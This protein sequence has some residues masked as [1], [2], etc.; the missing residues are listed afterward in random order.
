[1]K[2]LLVL[3]LLV[4]SF[5]LFS[6]IDITPR[7]LILKARDNISFDEVTFENTEINNIFE[8]YR[9]RSI[10]KLFP[11]DDRYFCVRFYDDLDWN[12]LTKKAKNIE[13]IEYIQPNYVNKMHFY[14]NDPRYENQFLDM[15]NAEQSWDI[16]TGSNS[17]IIAIIDSGCH[18]E[19][20]DLQG[21]I[22]I[23]S[24]EIA[25][26]GIDDDD[27]GYVDDWRGWDF[28]DAPE[29]SEVALGDYLD[30]DND[31]EDENNHGTHVAGIIGADS[32][33]SIGITGICH[34]TSMLIV[35]AGF[36]TTQGT[37]YLQDDDCASAIVYAANM[38]ANLINIS[39]GDQTHSQIIDDACQYAYDH[40]TIIVAS[41]GNDPQPGISFPARLATTIS[42]GA[43]DE[44]MNLGGFSSYG[45]EMDIVAPG[46][47]IISTYSVDDPAT[48]YHE[49]SGTSMAAPFV[50]GA[51]GL[52]LSENPGISFDEAKSRLYSSAYNLGPVGFD[53]YFGMGMLDIE[54][55]LTVSTI[56]L[57]EITSPD[58]RTGFANSFD[59]V[60]TVD[61]ED[62]FRYSVMYTS[63]EMPE[64]IDWK[65][66]EN[67]ETTPLFYTENVVNGV[68]A[69]FNLR[70][71][72]SDGT[73]LIKVELTTSDYRKFTS[74]R[75]VYLDQTSPILDASYLKIYKRYFEETPRYYLQS[76]YDEPVY[77]KT[78]ITDMNSK[79]YTIYNDYPDSSLIIQFPEEL[80]EGPV[81]L[82]ISAENLCGKLNAAQTFN[83]VGDIDKTTINTTEYNQIAI[84]PAITGINTSNPNIIIGM[85]AGSGYGDVHIF[86][87]S[88]GTMQTAYSFDGKFWPLD[89]GNTNSTHEELIGIN[90][91]KIVIYESNDRNNFTLPADTILTKSDVMGARFVNFDTDVYDELL[92]I[93]NESF[94][95]VI[96]GYDRNSNVFINRFTLHNTSPT[97]TRN[98][99]STRITCGDFDNDGYTDIV[100][101]DSDGDVMVYEVHSNYETSQ[102]WAFRLPT[103]NAFFITSG[104]YTGDG[105]KEFC[106]GGYTESSGNPEKTFSFFQV[107]KST[108]P[109]TYEPLDYIS[110]DHIGSQNS[111]TSVDFDDDDDDE[112]VISMSPGVYIVDYIDGHL[113]P[114]WKGESDRTYQAFSIDKNGSEP[115][116]VFLNNT[117]DDQYEC[118]MVTKAAV[119]DRPFPPNQFKAAPI[120]ENAILLS[121]KQLITGE[122]IIY[123]IEDDNM[124]ELA[125]VTGN[126]FIDTL[127]VASKEYQYALAT[128]D[129][130][131]QYNTSKLSLWKTVMPDYKPELVEMSFIDQDRLSLEFSRPLDNTAVDIGNY[132]I[133]PDI[134]LPSSCYFDKHKTRVIL[135]FSQNFEQD[136]PYTLSIS[137]LKGDSGVPLDDVNLSVTLDG[138]ELIKPYI[139]NIK[140]I[141]RNHLEINYSEVVSEI[142]AT[143]IN[144]YVIS[145]PEIDKNNSIRSITYNNDQVTIVFSNELEYANKV[146]DLNVKNVE[147]LD[148]N[149]IKLGNKFLFSLTVINNLDHVKIVPNPLYTSKSDRFVIYNLPLNKAGSIRLYDIN[150]DLVV[151][152]SIEGL[153]QN[154]SKFDFLP[155][156]KMGEDLSSGVYYYIL[157]IGNDIKKG[158]IAV[159]R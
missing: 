54:A 32:D 50:T 154:E 107:F 79:V 84:G 80:A 71:E 46:S 91:D 88:A 130:S 6:E 58:D 157:E 85:E 70:N 77:Q 63:S 67:H 17:I 112:L 66:V 44:D 96:K 155:R 122:V 138:S 92:T 101:S 149:R 5:N 13:E 118:H 143:N 86:D 76:K 29:L 105:V 152:K 139:E 16:T 20:E 133:T 10:K 30:Q 124:S 75:T 136:V 146:Y 137:N 113:V 144:N 73:Y 62:F 147:D 2:R 82:Q 126:S 69:T 61:A 59:I 90:L 116:K 123:K 121:W 65:N 103:P 4:I 47:Q 60:G 159:I 26:N 34:N 129:E 21:N 97:S 125:R 9:P 42:V 89:V 15:V 52:L 19:H 1:M 150:G 120:N 43:V 132:Y 158:K 22:L 48:M 128:Y 87:I 72:I 45:P 35:R 106:V 78:V 140:V 39:W 27:N 83:S 153:T 131:Y 49:M 95:R 8:K 36:R 145:F 40:G 141:D 156:N 74:M 134:K 119:Q 151:N 135:A 104:D 7:E 23:N 38:G 98:S 3:T 115:S 28:S 148:G 114:V 33:N 102:T 100:A 41:A 53:N 18:F 99:F 57:V 55:L 25:D 108:G 109:D 110:F 37:G 68:L 81:D 56:P 31:A 117:L 94:A 12:D 64:Q 51:L 111:I 24:G 142:T 14:P 11:K 127:V 93:E